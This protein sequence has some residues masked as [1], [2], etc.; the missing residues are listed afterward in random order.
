MEAARSQM[1]DSEGQEEGKDS[2][3]NELQDWALLTAKRKPKEL[4]SYP[5][6]WEWGSE[7]FHIARKLTKEDWAWYKSLPLSIY[8]EQTTVHHNS[9]RAIKY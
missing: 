3:V 2:T 6:G 8:G 7:H 1:R 4:P 9:F 5:E